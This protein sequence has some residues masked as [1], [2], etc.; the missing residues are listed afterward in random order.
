M[1]NKNFLSNKSRYFFNKLFIKT[2]IYELDWDL[3]LQYFLYFINNEDKYRDIP[4][5]SNLS[6]LLLP[7]FCEKNNIDQS[8]NEKIQFIEFFQL[9]LSF[10]NQIPIINLTESKTKVLYTTN[11]TGK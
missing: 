6:Q 9:L 1:I 11:I 4:L 5:I 7:S 2:I 8:S 3:V 10:L